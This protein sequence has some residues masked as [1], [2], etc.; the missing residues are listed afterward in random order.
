MKIAA[1]ELDKVIAGLNML[2]AFHQDEVEILREDAE[3]L[4]Q[5]ALNAFKLK[6]RGVFVQAST[7]GSLEALVEFL[8]ASSIPVNIL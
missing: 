4:H 1:K 5:N 8:K 6:D 7:L 3:K 2:V